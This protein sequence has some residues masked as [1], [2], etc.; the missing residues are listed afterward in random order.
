ML[1]KLV[2]V[3]EEIVNFNN[4]Q[5]HKKYYVSQVYINPYHVVVLKE[6]LQYVELNVKK[7]L[8]EGF[9]K[10]QKFTRVLINRGN[11]GEEFVVVG[12]IKGIA[13]KLNEGMHGNQTK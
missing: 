1:I 4:S 3:N 11:M 13:S 6:D 5:G 7:H 2:T 12:D 8:P 10:D 9:E